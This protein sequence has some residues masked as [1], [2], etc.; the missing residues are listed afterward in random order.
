MKIRLL[1]VI[2]VSLLLSQM[3][4][5]AGTVSLSDYSS[6]PNTN[7]DLLDAE[8]SFEVVGTVLTIEIEN[9][10]P[11]GDNGFNIRQLYFNATENV[12]A[13]SL[14]TGLTNWSLSTALVADGFGIFDYALIGTDIKEYEIDGEA[15]GTF[16]LTVSG[17]DV[18]AADF[19]TDFSITEGQ[20]PMILV[21]RFVRGPSNMSGYGA[22]DVPEPGTIA[23]LGLGGLALI[24]KRRA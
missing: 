10:T 14:D 16:T 21:A 20:E 19:Y 7:A 15:I 6:S 4:V 11:A 2:V 8:V 24:R 18:S 23:L 5:H 17:S 3:S 22:T 13:L 1:A 9:L 12:T